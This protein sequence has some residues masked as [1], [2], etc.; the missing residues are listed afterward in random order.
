MKKIMAV[1]LAFLVMNFTAMAK[2]TQTCKVKY[3][4][5]YNWSEYYTVDVVFMS[6]SELNRATSTFDYET[7]SV[8]AIV[9]WDDDEASVIKI[10]SFTACGLEVKQNCISNLIYNLEGED[11]QG[12]AWEVCTRNLCY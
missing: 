6:G 7:F 10:S 11:Q 5:N 3:K 4:N 1:F 9:F 8:Y 2:Y 12:R